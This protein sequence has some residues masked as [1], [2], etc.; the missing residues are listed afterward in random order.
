MEDETP[1][2]LAA[3]LLVALANDTLRTNARHEN[4]RLIAAE[5][6]W[7]L[8]AQRMEAVYQTAIERFGRSAG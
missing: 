7:Q 2:A 5:E 1:Q 6:N 3:A 4:P 8:N